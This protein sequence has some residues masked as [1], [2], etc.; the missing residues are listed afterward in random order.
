MSFKP[1]LK[2]DWAGA[3]AARFACERWHYSGRLPSGK[4]M[5]LGVWE[6]GRYVG[7]VIFGRGANNNIGSRYAIE[8]D[9]VCEL[10]RVALTDHVHPVSRI[11]SIAL[12]LIKQ[13]APGLRLVVSYADPAQGHHGGIYQ[14]MNWLYAGTSQPQRELILNGAFMHKRTATSRFGT[15]SPERIAELTGKPCTY[16]P[17]EWKLTYLMPLDAG[18]RGQIETLRRDYPKRDKQAMAGTTGTATVQH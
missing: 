6:G 8:Q 11:V 1:D 3:D 17:K 10:V 7:A 13:S 14:A 9:Q 12:K 18:M 2:L 5:I 16:G 15:A 4:L